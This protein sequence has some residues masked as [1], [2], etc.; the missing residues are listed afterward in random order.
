MDLQMPTAL[1]IGY[2][3]PCQKARVITEA[4]A[5][6]ELFCT[7][8]TFDSLRRLPHNSRSVDFV[9]A[10]CNTPFQLKAGIGALGRSIPD[11]AYDAMICSI[12]E[13]RTPNLLLL[14]YHPLTWQVSDLFLIPRFAFPESSVV[15]RKP[16]SPTARRAGWI[17][18][19]IAL[20]RIAPD[21]RIPIIVAGIFREK[22]DVRKQLERLKPLRSLETAA[23]GW[24]LDVLN[25]L[26]RL[27]GPE[28]TTADAYAFGSELATLHPG[29][30]H[31]R[32]KIRQ[33]LQVLRDSGILIHTGR[34]CWGFASRRNPPTTN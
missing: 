23:R 34:G 32:A 27:P 21:A 7:D 18:C 6:R 31:I 11:G 9:C 13:N 10:D 26:R 5:E 4:W 8:C 19:N 2:K 33:Q 22:K 17:G 29:N 16:L 12:R 3:S 24:A 14:R 28:F 20:D 30:R 15:K 25:V 1:G